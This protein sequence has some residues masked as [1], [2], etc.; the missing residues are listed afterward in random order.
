MPWLFDI[1]TLRFFV[2][3]YVILLVYWFGAF[4]VPVAGWLAMRWL[5]T[6][7]RRNE[8]AASGMDKVGATLSQLDQ[9]G[10][11]RMVF[12]GGFA[13]AFLLLELLW[14]ML[15]EFLIAYYHIHDALMQLSRP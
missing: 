3:P 5:V 8:L 12:W 1:I 9:D 6:R 15:F 14:R 4:V 11:W 2:T 7:M 13:G 10:G